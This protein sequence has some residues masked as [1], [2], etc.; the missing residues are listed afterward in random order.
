MSKNPTAKRYPP[1][2]KERTLRMVRDLRREDPGDHGVVTRVDRQ[3]GVA[4]SPC[5][6]G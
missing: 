2:L 6:S 5:G 3:L 4:P 1:E